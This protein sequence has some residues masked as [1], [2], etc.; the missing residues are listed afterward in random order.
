M[1]FLPIV[2]RELR[3]RARLKSTHRFRLLAAVGAIGVVGLLLLSVN[4]LAAAGQFGGVVFAA[5]AWLSFAYCLLDGARNTADCL[6]SEKRDG[7]LG[8]LFLTDLRPYDVVLGKLMATSLNSFYGLLA[9]FP[10]L[11]IPLV[12]GGVTVGEFWRLVLVLMNTLFFSVVIGL[13]VSSACRDERRAWSATVLLL[14][15]FTLVPPLLLLT[16]SWNSSFAAMLSPATSFLNVFDAAYSKTPDRYW[17]S[18]WSVQALSWTFLFTAMFV[19]PRA[20]QDRPQSGNGSWWRRMTRRVGSL[21][22]SET[23]GFDK[24]SQVLDENPV[25]WLVARHGSRQTLLWA[26]VIGAS[27]VVTTAWFVSS[28]GRPTALVLFGVMFLVHLTLASAVASEAC[29]LFA[30]ARDSGALELLL[31]TPI[32]AKQIVE[33]HL[34]GLKQTYLRPVLTLVLVEA[35]LLA[36]QI[37]VMGVGGMSPFSCALVAFAVGLC[38]LGAV[39][40]LAAVARYGMWQGLVNRKPARAITRTIL[41]VL[42]LPFM[43]ALIVTFG[44]GLPLIWPLKNLVFINYSREQMR[45]Q[46]RGALA[47]RYGWAEESE[48]IGQDS[49]RPRFRNL[50]PVLPR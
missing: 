37:Y 22:S 46:F 2:E 11:A 23:N 18:L 5:L 32:T 30:G 21:R 1:T 42:V 28:G 36:G 49:N 33:G 15:F 44:F 40:D 27:I 31:S 14:L 10:P 26:L 50:P 34:L 41:F 6:S 17:S 45:R 47:E 25:V 24:R 20:W 35:L 9:I 12:I 43:A 3:V 7:T 8:L 19:L 16:T 13:A 39:M 4:T 38:L 29:H 48:L